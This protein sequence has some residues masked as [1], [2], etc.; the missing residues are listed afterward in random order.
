LKDVRDHL[1]TLF[2]R[3]WWWVTLLVLALMALLARLG[4]WQ[5]DRLQQRRANNAILVAALAQP[6]LELGVDS[7]PPD[8]S[9]LKDRRLHASGRFDF[10]RQVGLRAQNWQGR[11]G[12][13]LITPLVLSTGE[14]D[15][16]SPAVLVDRGWI[17]E[18]DANPQAWSRYDDLGVE[19]VEGVVALTEELRNPD[20]GGESEGPQDLW[21]RVDITGIQAQMP[22]ELLPFYVVQGPETTAVNAEPPLRALPEVDLSEGPH[23]GYAVQWFIFSLGLGIAYLA[24]VRRQSLPAQEKE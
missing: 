13:H 7:L 12:I 20:A 9:S 8:V 5:L 22:Y 23:L 16:D 18:V 17:P 4:V 10:A 3:R 11:A 24:F 1:H 21:Y 15:D 14:T 6:P 19:T 2:S